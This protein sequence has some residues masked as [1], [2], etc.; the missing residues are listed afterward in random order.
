METSEQEQEVTTPSP[1]WVVWLMGLVF[2]AVA[3]GTGRWYGMCWDEGYYYPAYV[4]VWNWVKLIFHAPSE[5]FSHAG[6]VNG[7]E[8]IHELPP[9]T[10]WFGAA[11]VAIT[12]KGAELPILRLFPAVLFGATVSLIARIVHR[13]TDCLISGLVAGAFYGLHPRIFGH[14]HFAASETVFAFFTA[15]FLYLAQR[16][17]DRGGRRFLLAIVLGLAIATKVNGF[18]MLAATTLWFGLRWL[19]STRGTEEESFPLPPARRLAGDGA[20]FAVILFIALLTAWIVWPWMWQDTFAR[21]QEY[22]MFIREHSFQGV[23]YAGEKHNYP[24]GIVPMV[25]WEYPWVMTLVTSPTIWVIGFFASVGLIQYGNQRGKWLFGDHDLLVGLLILGPLTAMMLPTSPKYDGIRLFFPMFVPLAMVFGWGV[26]I[27]NVQS[28][29]GRVLPARSFAAIILLAICALE[30]LPFWLTGLSYYNYPTRW[31]GVRMH[32]FPFEI[33]YW[34][35][36]LTE[37]VFD[38]IEE[39]FPTG[40]VKIKTLALHTAVFDLQQQWGVIPARFEFDG[41]P[42]Y[43]AHLMQ[44]RKGFWG[45]TEWWF[46]DQRVPLRTWPAESEDPRVYL[47]DG[48]PP[49]LT[50]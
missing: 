43:D 40:T 47:F 7:W 5:A 19:Y 9:V 28:I 48:R 20:R 11:M 46:A 18:I 29:V 36:A 17:L 38:D 24:K 30:S 25:T 8:R 21:L 12:P 35:E 16:N 10:K 27:L 15:L 41:N 44:N 26:S 37:D 6:I 3:W 45:R 23:W 1:G 14:A 31:L 50:D 2:A 22:W 33:T 34:G 42:P 13:R 49:E 32:D 39:E 4:D